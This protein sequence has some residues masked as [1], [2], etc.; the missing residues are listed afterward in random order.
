[1]SNETQKRNKYICPYS[2]C[3]LIP[4]VLSVHTDSGKIVL[5]CSEG[6]LYEL[7][8]EEYFKIL[9]E[10]KNLSPKFNINEISE[11][12][13]SDI[14]S[15]QRNI[16]EKEEEIV[17]I[18]KFNELNLS[19]LDSYPKNYNYKKNLLNIEKS[20]KEENDRSIEL[21][22]IIKKEIVNEKQEE[23]EAL[24]ELKEK[25]FL[26]LEKFLESEEELELKLKGPKKE[27]QCIKYLRDEGFKL[28]SKLRFKNLIEINFANNFITN[29]QPLNDMLLPHLKIIN[30]SENLITDIS[31][32]A[33]LSSH[34]LSEIY[35]QNNKIQDLGPFL[36]SEFPLLE[37]FRV[38]GVGNEQAFNKKSFKAV[39]KKYE[40]IIYYE[41]KS[42]DYFNEE[43]KFDWKENNYENLYRLDLSSTRKEKILIDL[44]PLIIYPNNIKYLILDDNKLQDVSLLSRMPLY[45]L[46]L[47]DLSLNFIVNIKF[48]KK[49]TKKWKKL[50]TL[51]LN[52]NKIN[53][54][55]PLITTGD[56]NDI[57]LILG[58]ETLTLKNNSLDLKDQTTKN[59]IENFIKNSDLSFDYEENDLYDFE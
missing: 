59:I 18:I 39:L 46:I 50:K 49:I 7:D 6:H 10:K 33:N 30:F 41:H 15:S 29:L 32:I 34:N 4:E 56:N 42:L 54:I 19:V 58:L 5:K 20:I 24:I 53:E 44:F 17:N 8:V 40:N 21:D 37:I 25:Y 48:L 11:Q 51:Y 2:N 23:K 28:I 45:N 38:D 47:L 22:N 57:K 3:D 1:M 9:E 14:I 55:S 36:N 27:Y 16:L 43:Y 35:L 52:D 12:K 31:P 13:E 26:D